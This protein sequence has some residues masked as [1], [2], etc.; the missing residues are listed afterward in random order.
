[1]IIFLSILLLIIL[2]LSLI[3]FSLLFLGLSFATPWIPLMKKYINR[4]LEAL[5]IKLDDILYD[6]GCGDGRIVIEAAKKYHIQARGIELVWWLC[7]YANWRIK[8]LGLDKLA[9]VRCGDI[10]KADYSEATAVVL[11]LM[12]ALLDRLGPKL[13]VNLKPG[14]RVVSVCFKIKALTPVKII[15]PTPQDKPVYYYII[16]EE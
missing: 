11:F 12:P 15:Q 10:L 6:L 1:M 14:T 16:P 3:F 5:E 4:S 2:F 7:L 9:R 8:F 13:L